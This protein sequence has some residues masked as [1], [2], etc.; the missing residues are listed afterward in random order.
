MPLGRPTTAG[1]GLAG[2]TIIRDSEAAREYDARA[3][4]TNWYVPEVVFGLAYEFVAPG[5][6]ILDLGIGSGLSSLPFH[7][8]GLRVYGLDGS[9]EIL[10]VCASKNFAVELK[11]HDL[12]RMPLPYPSRSFD[13]VICV[14]V[15]NSFPDL[16]PLFQEI[17]RVTRDAGIFAFTV[18]PQ[19]PGR[20]DSYEINRENV[21]QGPEPETAVKLY[22]HS[23]TYIARLL[24]QNGFTLRKQLEFVAFKYPAEHRNVMFQAYVAR[25]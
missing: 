2:D 1:E 17:A 10:Q 5:Q 18:E 24:G 14:G 12:R 3:R 20:P 7:K 6:T 11:Q 22:R 9:P 4:R 16:G 8:L 25:L 19:E 23:D 21:A 15:L 13:H